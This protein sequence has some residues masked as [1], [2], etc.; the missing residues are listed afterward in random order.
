MPVNEYLERVRPAVDALNTFRGTLTADLDVD[1]GGFRYWAGQLDWKTRVLLA[2]YLLQTVAG[3][4]EALTSAS[5]AAVDHKE[6]AHAENYAVRQAWRELN[7]RSAHRPSTEQYLAA[8]PRGATV[9]R[10]A[11]RVVASA[12]QCFFHLGQGL[13]RIAAAIIIVGGYGSKDVVE[14]DWTR[15][16]NLRA[17]AGKPPQIPKN[18]FDYPAI[19]AA[20]TP[21]GEM[22]RR[23]LAA[24]D[25]T[26]YGPSA[27]LSWL[28]DT[29]NAM[30]HRSPSKKMN[31]MV[32]G[33]T[34]TRV[35][36]RHPK[37]SEI[38]S[39]VYSAQNDGSGRREHQL[40]FRQ[41]FL[42]KA[43]TDVLDGLCA[44]V[45]TMVVHIIESME[46][47][48]AARKA[49]PRL[50]V[51][52]AVQW[53]KVEPRV[54]KSSQFDGYGRTLEPKLDTVALNPADSLRWQAAR[55]HDSRWTDWNR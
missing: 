7:R 47:C 11:H 36:Y 52:H 30:T 15:I 14:A 22:Q 46:Q 54:T 34:F 53:S 31:V 12:E 29:R 18:R 9:D 25:P 19:L 40:A 37:W 44:S 3:A 48:W 38:Q 26:P 1:S 49:D 23:L 28:R 42:M 51:Q 10:R 35:F 55:V 6:N 24:T 13:D 50:V 16:E 27:W 32:D 43:S 33:G 20:E 5:L 21:G 8:M 17:T 41:Q 45:T 2:D 4:A 39:F